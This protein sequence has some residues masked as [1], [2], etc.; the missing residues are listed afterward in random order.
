VG[1]AQEATAAPSS[2][3]SK[4]LPGVLAVKL[5]AA[6]ALLLWAGGAPVMV[7]SGGPAS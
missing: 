7:V 2:W 3:H 4:P 1:L 6:S 5:N